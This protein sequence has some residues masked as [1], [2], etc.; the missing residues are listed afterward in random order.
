M[1]LPCGMV[2]AVVE[3]EEEKE[4]EEEDIVLKCSYHSI[5][6]CSQEL[7]KQWSF[8]TQFWG[9]DDIDGV[10]FSILRI[11]R[12]INELVT[13]KLPQTQ[14]L[15]I[16]MHFLEDTKLWSLFTQFWRCD[17]IKEVNCSKCQVLAI[18]NILNLVLSF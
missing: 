17:V 6:H 12:I 3:E 7:S 9:C 14:I 5:T 8:Y 13:L 16:L 15:G 18:M 10:K 1:I 4:E 11:L 2:V